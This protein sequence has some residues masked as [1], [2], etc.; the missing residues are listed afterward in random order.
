MTRVEE[1]QDTITTEL[2]AFYE[3]RHM[4][5]PAREAKLFV[6]SLVDAVRADGVLEG[7]QEMGY[8]PVPQMAALEAIG[9]QSQVAYET[10]KREGI[11]QGRAEVNIDKHEAWVIAIEDGFRWRFISVPTYIK[12]TAD[13]GCDPY[14]EHVVRIL[15]DGPDPKG[16]EKQHKMVEKFTKSVD[17][18]MI[19]AINFRPDKER[20]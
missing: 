18:I 5:N 8:N 3:D 11:E 10:G 16:E 2:T 14:N 19:Q 20:P 7:K 6:S 12:G 9:R 17:D 13:N 4:D 15:L 1:L